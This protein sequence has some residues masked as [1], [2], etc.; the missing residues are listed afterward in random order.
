MQAAAEVEDA[1]S[2]AVPIPLD[3]SDS[4]K[5]FAAADRIEREFG[6]IDVWVNVASASVFAPFEQIAPEE[7]RRVTEVSYLGYV[8]GTMVA[9]SHMKRRD[10]GTIVQVGTALAYRGIPLQ[11]AYCGAKHAIQGFGLV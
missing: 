2:T 8:Y 9:L 10:R 4:A 5:V 11:T 7:Y 3:A 1:G 6:P